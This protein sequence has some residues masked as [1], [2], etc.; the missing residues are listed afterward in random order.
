[1]AVETPELLY[2]DY[3]ERPANAVTE[4]E[5][6]LRDLQQRH[7]TSE[8]TGRAVSEL[9]DA[10]K[11]AAQRKQLFD[12]VRNDVFHMEKNAQQAVKR[13]RAIGKNDEQIQ[14]FE[15]RAARISTPAQLA[16]LEREIV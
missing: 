14:T 10:R 12:I 7:A 2:A 8:E 6:S 4:L 13:L 1:M 16:A 3:V 5:S 11:A 15:K 9:E